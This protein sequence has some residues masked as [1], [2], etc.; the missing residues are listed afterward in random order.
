MWRRA[1]RRLSAARRGV[2]V[3]RPVAAA[4]TAA[5]AAASTEDARDFPS[6]DDVEWV[7]H[8]QAG[9]EHFRRG[10]DAAAQVLNEGGPDEF[11][12][13]VGFYDDD[14]CPPC[15]D[16][17]AGPCAD[18]FEAFAAA[19]SEVLKAEFRIHL[20]PGLGPMYD[21]DPEHLAPFF[22]HAIRWTKL[23]EEA[24]EDLARCARRYREAEPLVAALP[25]PGALKMGA[26]GRRGDPGGGAE[27]RRAAMAPLEMMS[28]DQAAEAVRLAAEASPADIE[29]YCE[30]VR[31]D[32]EML[33]AAIGFAL[34]RRK[35]AEDFYDAAERGENPTLSEEDVDP[36]QFLVPIVERRMERRLREEGE[37][38]TR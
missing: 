27:T 11:A 13:E 3:A 10:W 2:R 17:R 37:G 7:E 20:A 9:N 29:S 36:S 31:E 18:A 1:W 32:G 33:R 8:P 28:P 14:V 6:L 4:A 24:A 30:R 21:R 22:S 38:G 34:A 16:L 19:R 5:A 26:G 35:V 15:R 23:A 12:L 25:K